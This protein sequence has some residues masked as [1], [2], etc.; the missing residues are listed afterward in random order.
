MKKLSYFSKITILLLV[1]LLVVTGLSFH[2]NSVKAQDSSTTV[3][4]GYVEWPG[5]TVKT[6]VAKTITEY[7]GYNTEMS[8]GM[9]PT[10]LKGLGTKDLDVFLGLWLPQMSNDFEPYQEKGTI[11][12]VRVNLEDVVWRT[13]VPEYVWEAGIRSHEDL[14]EHADKFEHKWYGLEAGSSGNDIM[15]EAIENDIYDLGDWEVITS[16]E[17]GMMSAVERHVRR[18]EWIAFSAWRPHWMNIEY[19]IKYLEDPEYIWAEEGTN[20]RVLTVTREDFEED[21]PNYYKFLSQFKVPGPIQDKW[22]LEY[23]KNERPADEVAEEWIADNL[24]IVNQ[25]VFGV[26]SVDGRMARKVIAEKVEKN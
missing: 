4:F 19:D 25:W 6:H 18:E 21:M 3:R 1:F 10:V 20:K 11:E 2:L 26:Q 13:G 24:D 16:S 9:K 12:K 15:Q 23:G 7:L 17:A 5:V 8:S 14:A 22:I